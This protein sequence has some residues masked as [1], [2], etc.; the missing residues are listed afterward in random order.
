MQNFD[1]YYDSVLFVV[2][3]LKTICNAKQTYKIQ[4]KI[5][6]QRGHGEVHTHVFKQV[7][8]DGYK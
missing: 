4:L 3:E 8:I 2:V 6:T 1:G 7:L 5:G